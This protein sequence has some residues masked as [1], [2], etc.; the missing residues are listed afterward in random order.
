MTLQELWKNSPANPNKEMNTPIGQVIE[1]QREYNATGYIAPMVQ[2][3]AFNRVRV[4]SDD[5]MQRITPSVFAN[6]PWDETSVN[7]R[8]LPTIK[9]INT[10]RDMGYNV[11]MAGQSRTRIQGKRE[12]VKHMIR[13]RHND[14]M[15]PINVGDEIPEIVLV[16]AHS[17]A[18][19][20][21]LMLG[22][23]RLVC[24]NGM[25]V[26]SSTIDSL[27]VR[28]TGSHN[29]LDDV[30]DVSARVID[31]APKAIAQIARFKSIELSPAEQAAFAVSA[32]EAL[33]TTMEIEPS[34]ILAVRRYDD[35]GDN[36]WKVSNRVQ[37]NLIKG[38]IYGRTEGSTFRRTREVKS[39]N[40]NVSINK[41]IWRLTE[42]MAKLKS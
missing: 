37:E 3:R 30:I 6:R 35:K 17:G 39:I 41:A 14:F 19:A 8:F 24:S 31:E 1:R 27:S 36:L 42:E 16:N 10:F 15:S 23:F 33:P 11:T 18:S 5:D 28:H 40:S 13:L 38:G 2:T 22:F 25:I 12:F 26:A 32:I 4:Y 34:R 21:K 7:Y 20:Y 9:I 29:L